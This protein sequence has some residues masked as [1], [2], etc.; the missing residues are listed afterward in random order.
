M[1]RK[2]IKITIIL[3]RF[4]GVIR[5]IKPSWFLV[6]MNNVIPDT[7]WIRAVIRKHVLT[8]HL[9]ISVIEQDDMV[10]LEGRVPT[11]LDRERAGAVAKG[12]ASPG[13]VIINNL[14]AQDDLADHALNQGNVPRVSRQKLLQNMAA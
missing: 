11:K 8:R 12:A 6:F 4:A 7:D 13:V 14:K 9:Y 2:V 1:N 3:D 5:I 10:Y